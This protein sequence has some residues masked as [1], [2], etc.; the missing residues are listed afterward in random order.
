[1]IV[2]KKLLALVV[3]SAAV[4]ACGAKKADTNPKATEHSAEHSIERPGD[5][6]GG[7]AYGGAAYGRATP[8]PR[9][10][11]AGH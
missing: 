11:T 7:A 5:A 4:A 1:M 6:T 8:A 2:M 9:A 10:P 3:L